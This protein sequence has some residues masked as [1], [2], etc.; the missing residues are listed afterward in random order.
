M[1]YKQIQE[2]AI[3]THTKKLYQKVKNKPVEIIG[4]SIDTEA[5]VNKAK[6]V[7]LKEYKLPWRQVI[8]GKGH[9]Y[10]IWQ[11]YGSLPEK[12]KFGIPLYVII[13]QSGIIRF[14]DRDI[15]KVE[16]LINQLLKSK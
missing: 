11:V 12:L 13:D 5:R 10:P 8:E 1:L 3:S 16:S 2:C 6:D 7:V 4:I 14:G 15:K 9:R